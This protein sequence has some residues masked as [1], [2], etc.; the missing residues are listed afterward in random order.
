MIAKRI[1]AVVAILSVTAIAIVASMNGQNGYM[2]ATALTVILYITG[3]AVWSK[4]I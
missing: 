4:Q 2:H 3:R 1:I